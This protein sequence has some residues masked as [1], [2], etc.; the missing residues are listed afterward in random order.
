[1]DGVLVDSNP[2]HRRAWHLLAERRGL[3]LAAGDLEAR[4]FGRRTADGVRAVWGRRLPA[5]HVADLVAEKER[6]YRRAIAPAIA[7]VPGLLALVG[8]LRDAGV[9]LALATSAE[10]PNVAQV[11]RGLELRAAFRVRVLGRDVARAKPDPAIFRL[12]ATR[13]GVPARACLVVEDSLAGVVAAGRAGMPC[14]GIAT[15]HTAA[16]LRAA[17]AAL[18]VRDFRTRRLR[19]WLGRALGLATG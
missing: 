9:P 19:A 10:A 17:G 2:F 3:A 1:M 12:A 15:T 16:E 4:V 8:W 11:L 6:L 13:L 5:A 18:A 7:P 14:V